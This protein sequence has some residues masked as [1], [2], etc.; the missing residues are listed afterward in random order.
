MSME[1]VQTLILSLLDK[2]S[3]IL[4]TKDLALDGYK[5]DQNTVSGVLKS[6]ANLQ[7]T[8]HLTKVFLSGLTICFVHA[9]C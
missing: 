2:N 5:V 1:Q 4:D 7:V 9:S 6:L 3:V 8:L